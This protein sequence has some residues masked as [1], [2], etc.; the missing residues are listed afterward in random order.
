MLLRACYLSLVLFL[1]GTGSYPPF[2]KGLHLKIRHSASA[3]PHIGPHSLRASI[4]YAEQVGVN[5]HDGFFIGEIY[6]LYRRIGNIK[7]ADRTASILE[8]N[9]FI[10]CRLLRGFLFL[11]LCFGRTYEHIRFRERIL[12]V[13]HCVLHF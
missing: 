5:L 7:G 11:P 10:V 12:Q 8:I 6:F 2:E 13:T 1:F 3:L 4:A 9:L